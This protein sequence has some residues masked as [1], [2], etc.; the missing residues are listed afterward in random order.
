VAAAAMA[1]FSCTWPG[2]PLV[3]SGQEKPNKKRLSFFEKDFIDWKGDVALHGFYEAMLRFR[4]R[5]KA[6]QESASVIVLPSQHPDVLVYLCRRQ[7]DKVLVFLNFSQE[8]ARLQLNH[9]A[10]R[11][12]YRDLFFAGETAVERRYE[13]ELDG[14]GYV[15]L[16]VTSG[17]AGW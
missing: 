2:I 4:K 10:L 15:V 1:V 11:G 14:G 8:K 7:Q 17:N 6:L 5:N 3:Y 16:H 13:H 12:T 9:P